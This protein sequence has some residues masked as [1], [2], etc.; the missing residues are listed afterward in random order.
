[1]GGLF[2]YFGEDE[3]NNGGGEIVDDGFGKDVGVGV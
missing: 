1:M 3:G 2:Y